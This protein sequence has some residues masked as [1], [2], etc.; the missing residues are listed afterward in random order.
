MMD[1]LT[2]LSPSTGVLPP[3]IVKPIVR[4]WPPTG[5]P[6][7]YLR[8]SPHASSPASP[9]RAYRVSE[10][11]TRILLTLA[12]VSSTTQ[13]SLPRN[14]KRGSYEATMP[15]TQLT[16]PR[17]NHSGRMQSRFQRLPPSRR[18]SMATVWQQ[19]A[20]T[21]RHPSWMRFP[22]SARR[23]P[24]PKNH[25]DPTRPTSWRSKG[26]SKCSAKPSEMA[27]PLPASSTTNNAH[28]ADAAVPR[29]LQIMSDCCLQGIQPCECKGEGHRWVNNHSF[30]NPLTQRCRI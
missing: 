21:H 20:T 5:T 17:S 6:R 16:L 28:V 12:S 15:T 25:S 27:S 22:T 26:N 10:S 24:P 9:L 19:P 18:V 4:Q 7:W 13:D 8:Y 2:G 14:T 11:P 23:M 29:I 30:V 1:V 3:K